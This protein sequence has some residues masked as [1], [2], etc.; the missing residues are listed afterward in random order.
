MIVLTPHI[1]AGLCRAVVFECQRIVTEGG[2]ICGCVRWDNMSSLLF[3]DCLLSLSSSSLEQGFVND[4]ALLLLNVAYV[5]SHTDECQVAARTV[6]VLFCCMIL[7][8]VSLTFHL[9]MS[10]MELTHLVL[11]TATSISSFEVL[12]AE[13]AGNMLLA[14][15][16][17]QEERFPVRKRL[18]TNFAILPLIRSC[19]HLA[20]RQVSCF[21]RV[22]VVSFGLREMEN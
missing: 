1:P 7:R 8:E 21:V 12:A 2:R 6:Q 16:L 13:E 5:A 20:Y 11:M 22:D 19:T 10:Q 15:N 3:F 18:L 4:R 14:L 17:M 9:L